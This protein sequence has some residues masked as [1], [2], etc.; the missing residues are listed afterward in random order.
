M[1]K[2]MTGYGRGREITFDKY[3][4]VE[5]KSLN[6]KQ[7][8][9]TLK[10]P[11][12][13]RGA[14]GEVR[15]ILS[16]ALERGKV[17]LLCMLEYPGGAD[18][19][20]FNYD[21]LKIYHE[22]VMELDRLLGI[23]PPA[24]WHGV[25]LRLPDVLKTDKNTA[26]EDDE[27]GFRVAVERALEQLDHYRIDEGRKLYN[28][29]LEKIANISTLLA[30][31]EP[32]EEGRVAKIKSRI[33]DQLEKLNGVEVDRGRLEQEMIYYI[34]KLDISEEKQRLRTHLDYFIS[35]LGPA[36]EKNITSKGKKLGFIAQEMGREINTLGSKSNNAE[37]QIV[38]V[39]MK[40]ELEQIK[41]Q[42][43]NV[44]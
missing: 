12:F 15:S 21:A 41:E 10:V 32:L 19:P 24:D 2:S 5:L 6:S 16:S 23:D 31:V 9:L 20:E 34:E 35:T 17:E 26:S 7:L 39:K 25:L 37:M 4:T 33:I 13:F 22:R 36:D 1:I 30:E 3:I 28:F 38:V 18:T 42:V 43:L 29:F 40:D 44:L 11:Q 8:D 27:R 14:E